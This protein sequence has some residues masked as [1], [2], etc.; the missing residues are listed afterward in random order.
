VQP[1]WNPRAY[2]LDELRQI[3]QDESR[4]LDD[5][6]LPIEAALS[7]WP[8]VIL[9]PDMSYY[10]LQGQPVQVAKAPTNGML[11]LVDEKRGFIGVGVILSDGRVAP[12]RMLKNQ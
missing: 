11:R 4:H 10:L 3:S 1:F 7:D 8:Q 6:L 2:T 12:K 9:T 5:C